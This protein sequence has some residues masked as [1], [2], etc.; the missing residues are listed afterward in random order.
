MSEVRPDRMLSSPGPLSAHL[1]S[2]A[3]RFSF[4]TVHASTIPAFPARNATSSFGSTKCTFELDKI[5][6]RNLPFSHTIYVPVLSMHFPCH[7]VYE[8]HYIYFFKK[9]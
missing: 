6:R 1:W 2:R 5:S 9:N 7:Q 3:S 8:F 4:L